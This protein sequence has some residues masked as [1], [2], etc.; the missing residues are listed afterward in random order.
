MVV[1]SRIS[2][3]Y[4]AGST[5]RLGREV[6]VSNKFKFDRKIRIARRGSV[7]ICCLRKEFHDS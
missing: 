6:K 3:L 2:S 7:P 1:R 4:L 5:P